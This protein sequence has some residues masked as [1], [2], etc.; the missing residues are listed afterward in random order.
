VKR[1]LSLAV[2]AALATPA[3]AAVDTASIDRAADPCANFYGF[4]NGRWL[5]TTPIPPDLSRWG[6]FDGLTRA[7]DETLRKAMEEAA[8]A[9]RPPAG[10]TRRIALDYYASGMDEAAIARAGIAPLVPMLARIGALQRAQDLPRLLG[11]LHAV[12]VE[13]GFAFDV[14]PDPKESSRYVAGLS[15]GGLGLPDRD[16]YFLD[17]EKSRGIREAYRKHIA[18]VLAIEGDPAAAEADAARVFALETELARASMTAVERRDIDKTYNRMALAEIERAAP[19]FAWRE[20]FAALGAPS[21]ER[22]NVRQ[23]AFLARFAQLASERPAA[24]WRAYARWTLL[25]SASD[26]LHPAYESAHFDFFERVLTGKQEPA[27][28]SKR[29]LVIIGGRYGTAPLAEGLGQ[30]YVDRAFPPEAKARML[31]LVQ[32]IKDALR[33]RLKTV[34]WMTEETRAVSLQKLEAMRPRIGYPDKWRDLSTA[35]V[36]DKPFAEN[37]L[38]ANRY[39]HRRDVARIGKPVDRDEWRTSPHIVNAFYGASNNEI[40]FPAAILQPPFFDLK[41]DDASNYGGIGMVIGHEITHGFDDRGRRFDKEGNLRDWWKEEDARRYKERAKKIE[42]QYGNFTAIDGIK[43]N[44]ALTLGENISDV[45]GVKIAYLALQRAL[46]RKPQGT[47]DGF[48]ADQRFFLSFAN[49]WRAAMRPEYERLRLRTD[50]H[51]LPPLR[52]RGVIANMPEFARAFACEPA[53]VLLSED[54]RANIW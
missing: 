20:Y 30:V 47:I 36:G 38:A 24:D 11:E 8:G 4:A 7:S 26:K 42:A 40:V 15:Q 27:H 10:S 43:V 23:P 9:P 3:G 46:A 2:A 22:V 31:T 49:I 21:V 35:E 6:A 18:R 45:G 14:N 28:R 12:D 39:A 33:D 32:D 1:L 17:D 34:E 37:W 53:K 52:V 51:A 29:V 25:R 13:P 48:S 41:A 54:E 44:G 19:G 16:Y 5:A 50:S